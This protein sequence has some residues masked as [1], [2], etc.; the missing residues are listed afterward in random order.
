MSTSG[1]PPPTA[2]VYAVP[3]AIRRADI[4]ELC[5]DLAERLRGRPGGVVWCHVDTVDAPSVVTVEAVARLR[6]TADRHGW[7]LRTYGADQRLDRLAA[8]LGLSGL[9]GEAGGQA[10][11]REQ[12]GGV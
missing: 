12:A 6:L 8:F 7:S 4:P 3:P 11:Q 9:L 2:T 1:R 5:A 10:E